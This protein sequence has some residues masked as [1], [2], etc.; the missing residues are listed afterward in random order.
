MV[1]PGNTHFG[2]VGDPCHIQFRFTVVPLGEELVH[3]FMLCYAMKSVLF[4]FVPLL[5]AVGNEGWVGKAE[6]GI[7]AHV[8][9]KLHHT[10]PGKVSGVQNAGFIKEFLLH[11]QVVAPVACLKEGGVVFKT[12]F[13]ESSHCSQCNQEEKNRPANCLDRARNVNFT[14]ATKAI[15][16]MVQ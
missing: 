13:D 4:F 16:H 15:S 8:L 1:F 7:L 2:S 11:V 5:F 14:K 10:F 12:G 6:N 3:L 9:E